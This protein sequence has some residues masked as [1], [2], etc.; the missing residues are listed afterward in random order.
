MNRKINYLICSVVCHGE[1]E[2]N[3]V[4]QMQN[5]NRRNLHPIADKN[6]K[7]SININTINKFLSSQYPTEKEYIKKNDQTIHISNKKIINHKIFT[8]MDKD[9]T[10]D[11]M[12]K[13]YIDK[14]LFKGTWWGD[15]D[16]I[17]PIYFVPDMD[18]IFIKHGYPI[19]PHKSKPRQYYELF[20]TRYDEMI[21]MLSSLSKEESNIKILID[22]I[23]NN[24]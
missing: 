13:A 5:K 12:L 11:K 17:E 8:I 3:I 15:D 19:D 2:Y 9:E 24:S 14:S 21:E 20:A 4:L 1:C 16:L 23:R 22:Y 6:G 18:T 7:I 10:T